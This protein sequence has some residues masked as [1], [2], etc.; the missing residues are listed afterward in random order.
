MQIYGKKRKCLHKKRSTPTGLVWSTNMTA[1]T[2]C[3]NALL[4]HLRLSFHQIYTAYFC[5]HLKIILVYCWSR[6]VL[7]RLIIFS[8]F[9]LIFHL[10]RKP[11]YNIC[12]ITHSKYFWALNI[13]FN[14]FKTFVCFLAKFQNMTRCFILTVTLQKTDCIH[15]AIFSLPNL[16]FRLWIGMTEFSPFSWVVHSC[17]K[18]QIC[19]A[20]AWKYGCDLYYWQY[21]IVS[22]EY[23]RIFHICSAPSGCKKLVGRLK[24][25]RNGEKFWKK[26]NRY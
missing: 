13:D 4:D 17:Q 3:E 18:R 1:L 11:E 6:T 26:K 14:F 12:F 21:I 10:I 15:R 22:I 25:M 5:S 7:S 23:C 9:C 16:V 19:R 2:S 24:P 20:V 8:E